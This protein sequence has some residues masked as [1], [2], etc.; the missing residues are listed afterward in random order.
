M[1]GYFM[2]LINNRELWPW[3]K[4]KAWQPSQGMVGTETSS[5]LKSLTK[6]QQMS[7]RKWGVLVI[8]QIREK[9]KEENQ[10]R[11]Q[12]HPFG[13]WGI[14]SRK[15]QYGSSP[16]KTGKNEGKKLCCPIFLPLFSSHPGRNYSNNHRSICLKS[17][18]G[19]QLF[20]S[21]LLLFL[22]KGLHWDTMQEA[23]WAL[24]WN[25]GAGLWSTVAWGP[26][27]SMGWQWGARIL[28]L[29]F[30]AKSQ[31]VIMCSSL[32]FFHNSLGVCLPQEPTRRG[33]CD[34]GTMQVPPESQVFT[35]S[36]YFKPI[37]FF[38]SR[39]RDLDLNAISTTS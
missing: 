26:S 23:H 10:A 38:S 12:I 1:D 15:R 33:G 39:Q 7:R 3:K 6:I 16:T 5:I 22:F 20:D 17:Q 25:R 13:V 34:Q 30:C 19:L 32:L 14:W 27:S 2:S 8:W 31:L 28:W 21:P 29:G 18:D 9:F 36:N 4:Q 11:V 35:M 37:H 24:Q